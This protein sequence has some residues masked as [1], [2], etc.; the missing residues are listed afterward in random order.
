MYNEV[1][2]CNLPVLIAVSEFIGVSCYAA[3]RVVGVTQPLGHVS[4][5]IYYRVA[6]PAVKIKIACGFDKRGFV[7]IREESRGGNAVYTI[8][9]RVTSEQTASCRE[10]ALHLL[11]VAASAI[12]VHS[13]RVSPSRST[14]PNCLCEINFVR[15]NYLPSRR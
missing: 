13:P 11:I 10:L 15:S 2:T 7:F 8:A 5:Q 3:G 1:T 9:R 14:H 4:P 12:R 6:P